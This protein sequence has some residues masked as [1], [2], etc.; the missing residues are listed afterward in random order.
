MLGPDA[1]ADLIQQSGAERVA[2]FVFCRRRHNT[3]LIRIIKGIHCHRTCY[4]AR[5]P[6]LCGVGAVEFMLAI[7]KGISR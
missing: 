4:A 1:I 3:P 6:M 2:W 7:K 5:P